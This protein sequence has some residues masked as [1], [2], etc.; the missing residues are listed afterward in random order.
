M[1]SFLRTV[2]VALGAVALSCASRRP[3]PPVLS[4]LP[5]FSLTDQDGRPFSLEQMKGRPWIVDFI[6]THCA[7]T[8]PSTT[9]TWLTINRTGSGVPATYCP[10]ALASAVGGPWLDDAA[11]PPFLPHIE[12]RTALGIRSGDST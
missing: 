7:N 4:T 9:R 2:V 8:C 12:T 3:A 10:G 5:A 6:F 11:P 1:S